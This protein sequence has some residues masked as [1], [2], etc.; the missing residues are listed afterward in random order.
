MVV[1]TRKEDK[2]YKVKNEGLNLNDYTDDN[3]KYNNIFIYL[4]INILYI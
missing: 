1:I 3:T 4:I 2:S